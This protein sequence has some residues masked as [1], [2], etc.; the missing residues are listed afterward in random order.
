MW[1]DALSLFPH[2]LHNDAAHKQVLKWLTDALATSASA[3]SD[4]DS[5]G[6]FVDG[7]AFRA[8]APPLVLH[9]PASCGKSF[10]IRRAIAACGAAVLE[11]NPSMRRQGRTLVEAVGEATQSRRVGAGVVATVVVFEDVDIIFDDERGFYGGVHSLLRSTRTPIAL[12]GRG[13]S[14]LL[15]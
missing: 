15:A 10:S 3:E 7:K 6:D 13:H 1:S 5:D 9:G 2:P 12:I 4:D 8:A 14:V 11:V